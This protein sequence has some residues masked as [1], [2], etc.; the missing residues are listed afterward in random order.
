MYDVR[1][2]IR[3]MFKYLILEV[4]RGEPLHGYEIIQRIG[5]MLGGEYEP[6]PGVVYPTLQLLEDMD[7]VVSERIGR[8]NVYHITEKGLDALKSRESE[9]KGLM[10]DIESFREFAREV[11]REL[12]PLM[13][14]LVVSYSSLSDEGKER[15]RRSFRELMEEVR[16]VL[17]EEK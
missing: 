15:I 17:G 8:K 9:L 7:Y 12:F 14:R 13:R 5:E 6:S 4:L 10:R 11:G 3:G 1:P 16:S 2:K